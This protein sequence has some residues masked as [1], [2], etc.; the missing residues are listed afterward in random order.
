MSTNSKKIT[1]SDKLYKQLQHSPKPD[2]THL[3]D[4]AITVT[5][6]RSSQSSTQYSVIVVNMCTLLLVSVVIGSALSELSPVTDELTIK[7]KLMELLQEYDTSVHFDETITAHIAHNIYTKL[8]PNVDKDVNKQGIKI[9][10]KRQFA[11]SKTVKRTNSDRNLLLT[12]DGWET[13]DKE[14]VLDMHNDYR[15]N[16]ASGNE[17]DDGTDGTYPEASDMNKLFWDDA[18]ASVAQAYSDNCVWGHNGNRN[19][20]FYDYADKARF[21]YPDSNIYLGEN[22]AISWTTSDAI[23]DSYLTDLVDAWWEEATLWHYQTYS[24]ST[25][26]GAGHFTQV[27]LQLIH[28]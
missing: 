8:K 10:E 5:F 13:S 28:G 18:L 19:S 4:W 11:S 15:S 26:N 9:G 22:I 14:T 6:T 7:E 21:D 2:P 25:I 20:E 23:Q 16:V 17:A 24:S 3:L 27:K 12:S 1:E